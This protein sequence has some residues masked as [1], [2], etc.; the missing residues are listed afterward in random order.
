MANSKEAK[1]G[2]SC[3][4]CHSIKQMQKSSP[5]HKN[6]MVDNISKNRPVLFATDKQ[7]K[8]TTLTFKQET[9]F[10][11]MF[12]SITGSP[13][14][15]IDYSNQNFYTGNICMGCHTYKQNKHK[16]NICKIPQTGAENEKQNCNTCHMPQVQG[17]ATTIKITKT[18]TFHGFSGVRF[19]SK[20]LAK[21]IDIK[22]VK[23]SNGFDIQVT[24]QA[25]HNLFLHPLRVGMLKVKVDN[26]ELKST[27]FVRIIGHNNKPAM[28]W[29]AT[30]VIKD[31]MIKA[32]ETRTIHYDVKVTD[33][34][35]ISVVFGYFLVNPKVS[36]KLKIDDKEITEFKVLKSVN[37]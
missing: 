21:Y 33:K 6:L 9:H 12:K 14:H 25:P 22:L 3:I 4:Y 36:K 16:F 13:Y 30:K 20:M 18:H 7:K 31:T 17:S 34:S 29:N 5:S 19:N 8:G 37:F 24:N 32:K 28:P 2:I 35:N 15:D 26:K 1:E 11:G 23:K 27:T 10:F